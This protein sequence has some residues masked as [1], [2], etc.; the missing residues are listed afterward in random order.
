MA[1]TD[2][3]NPQLDS[4]EPRHI[5]PLIETIAILPCSFGPLDKGLD[6]TDFE[7]MLLSITP[8]ARKRSRQLPK[9]S[10]VDMA[11]RIRAPHRHKTCIQVLG[12]WRSVPFY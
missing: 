8:L 2:A 3:R 6:L 12:I 11:W 9:F 4:P 7:Y 10:A 5:V 1:I